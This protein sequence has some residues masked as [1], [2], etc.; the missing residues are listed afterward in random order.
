MALDFRGMADEMNA[1]YAAEVQESEYLDKL[2]MKK[3]DMYIFREKEYR[4]AIGDLQ[5]EIEGNAI[6]PFEQ[7]KEVSEDQLQ[8]M[9]IRLHLNQSSAEVKDNGDEEEQQHAN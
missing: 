2:L 8:L 4:Q 6:N 7:A 1:K 9:G 5:E 3:M